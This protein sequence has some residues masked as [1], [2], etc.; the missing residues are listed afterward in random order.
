MR[1][2]LRLSNL[3]AGAV[4]L[5]SGAAATWSW[6]T[7]PGYR[8]HYGDPLWLLLAYVAF[9]GWVLRAF[10]R[11]DA[12]A[13]RLAVAKAIGAYVFLA[14][15]VAAGPV[16]MARTPG[17]YVYLFFHDWGSY[18][19]SVLMAYV[20]LGRGLWNTVNAMA[21]T[22]PWWTAIRQARPILGRLLTAVPLM[23]MVTF[24]W[25]YREL[26]RLERQTYSAEATS[27]ASEILHGIDCAA[28]RSAAAPTTVDQRARD[29]RRYHV[30]IQWDCRD[31]R[32]RVRDPDKKLGIARAPKL[33]CCDEP[34]AP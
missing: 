7:D 27:V 3:V 1:R 34:A 11:D 26:V 13:P 19:Q 8:A 30:E 9:Y 5:A 31:V 14:S 17:R 21:F 23:L 15:F 24:V 16:W 28:I 10:W 6:I 4:C 18:S 33:E 25:T 22:M 32:V 29:D 12:W 20:L 2:V